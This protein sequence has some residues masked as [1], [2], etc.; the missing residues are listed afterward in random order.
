[1]RHRAQ[2]NQAQLHGVQ[3]IAGSGKLPLGA[4]A[5]TA[6]QRAQHL[7]MPGLAKPP[8]RAVIGN[9]EFTQTRR[10][11]LANFGVQPFSAFAQIGVLLGI[12][13][14]NFVDDGQHRNF[15]QDGVQPRPLDRHFNLARWQGGDADVF[16]V[17]LEDT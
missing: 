1:M 11:Q 16:F 15:K 9:L 14:I 3:D 7:F 5:Q 12:A 13:E 6:H 8:A 4:R 2:R 17:E 10:L